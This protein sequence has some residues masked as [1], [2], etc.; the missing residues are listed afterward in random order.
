MKKKILIF[1]VSILTLIVALS[2]AVEKRKGKGPQGRHREQRGYKAKEKKPVRG[3]VVLTEKGK[4]I[5]SISRLRVLVSSDESPYWPRWSPD[6]EWVVFMSQ[7]YGDY[8][9]CKI[10]VDGIGFTRLTEYNWC[11]AQPQFSLDGSKI[12]YIQR[13]D[14]DGD[15]DPWDHPTDGARIWIMDADGSNQ[16]QITPHPLYCSHF[17]EFSPDGSKIAYRRDDTKDLWMMNSDGTDPVKL[18][19]LSTSPHHYHWSPDGNKIAF[20]MSKESPFTSYE[21]AIGVVDVTTTE[22]IFLS[23]ITDSMCQKRPHWNDDGTKIIY[24]DDVD[25]TGNIWVMNPDGSGKTPLTDAASH[26]Y[27][28]Y[29]KFSFS[30]DGR[31]IVFRS[32]EN[33]E[34][35]PGGGDYKIWVMTEDGKWRLPLTL[36]GQLDGDDPYHISANYNMSRI[37]FRTD[38][39]YVIDLDIRDSDSDGLLNWEEVLY[40]TKMDNP[41]TDG[42]GE[43][44]GSEVE[45]GRDPLDPNDDV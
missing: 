9:I 40:R 14:G 36:D 1:S 15:G 31:Y 29:A 28:C 11:S 38:D 7:A 16:R 27:C 22:T 2:F 24:L 6:G 21:G 30:E 4:Q 20:D 12:V 17:P 43:S 37:L 33:Y 19:T 39:I 10:R 41:D 44:D 5:Q 8:E 18:T 45:N 32:D 35:I 42:G 3:E 23:D 26:E 25:R 34:D 13:V